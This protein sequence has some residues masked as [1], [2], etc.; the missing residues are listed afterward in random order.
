MLAIGKMMELRT[1]RLHD[2][3][4]DLLALFLFSVSTT[5]AATTHESLPETRRAVSMSG[6][7]RASTQAC[8]GRI[9][10]DLY[11]TND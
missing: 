3:D 7:S 4:G 1:D 11:D 2:E 9:C 6:E 5:P 8:G 10:I